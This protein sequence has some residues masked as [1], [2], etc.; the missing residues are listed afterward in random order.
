MPIFEVC[1]SVKSNYTIYSIGHVTLKWPSIYICPLRYI[2]G[3]RSEKSE[4][5]PSYTWHIN[6]S[7]SVISL[8]YVIELSIN[9]P[10]AT[11]R[12]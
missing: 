9:I 3:R 6:H 12:G 7:F 5:T 10:N 1:K 4:L 11:H 2:H 8:T